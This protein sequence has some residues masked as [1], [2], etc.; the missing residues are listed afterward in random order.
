[1]KLG[2]VLSLLAL[3][4]CVAVIVKVITVR[5][6]G[7]PYRFTQWDG[8]LILRGTTLGPNGMVGFTIVAVALG[9]IATYQLA[10]WS[11]L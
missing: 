6:R 1:M 10:R 11:A 3:V 5:R 8:G 2:I 4:W 9:A 7:E